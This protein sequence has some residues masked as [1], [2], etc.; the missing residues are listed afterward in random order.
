MSIC[1]KPDNKRKFK[2]AS[3]QLK[4]TVN[5]PAARDASCNAS[6]SSST[7]GSGG[8]PVTTTIYISGPQGIPGPTGPV[9]PQGP[10]PVFQIALDWK[11]TWVTGNTYH[12][13][14]VGLK[15]L[16]DIVK[17]EDVSYVCL[18]DHQSDATSTP[19][20]DEPKRTPLG[21]IY[22]T[23][24]TNYVTMSGTTPGAFDED[25]R[26]TL[27]K[28]AD[29]P[30]DFVNFVGK[31]AAAATIGDWLLAAALGA[32]I[33]YAGVKV[34]SGMSKTGTENST[35]ITY[36][37]SNGYSGSIAGGS[38]KSLLQNLCTFCGVTCDVTALT[39]H[40]VSMPI[41]NNPKVIDVIVELSNVY[42]FDRIESGGILK[43]IPRN[44]VPV[45]SLYL[46][47]IGYSN[48]TTVGSPIVY[49]RDQGINLPRQVSI[50]YISSAMDYG[51]FGQTSQLLSFDKGNDVTISTV[52]TLD[53]AFA[54]NL[55]DITLVNA[56]L[57]RS[58]VSFTTTL[59]QLE[60][61]V[62]DIV[63]L[64]TFGMVRILTIDENNDGLLDFVC[65]DAGSPT[66]IA[67]SEASVAISAPIASTN[68]T[69]DIGESDTFFLDLPP[70]SMNDTKSRLYACTHGYG[71]AGWPGAN[72]Y[73]SVDNGA[74]YSLCVTANEESTWGLVATAI[75]TV[76]HRIW[77]DTTVVTVVLKTGSLT[78]GTNTAVLN[79]ANRCM[80]GREMIAF[81]TATLTAPKTYQLTHLLRGRQGTDAFM[82]HEANELF[83][84][85]TDSLV[86]IETERTVP[87]M[88]K[89]VTIGSDISA[90][91]ETTAVSMG[92]NLTP[93]K[94]S[95]PIINKTSNDWNL[96]WQ[97]RLRYDNALKDSTDLT[98]DADFGGWAIAVLDGVSSVKRTAIVWTKSYTYT[99]AMQIIDF[100]SNQGSVNFSITALSTSGV[101]GYPYLINS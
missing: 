91:D 59:D 3:P 64:E 10:E 34:I 23:P 67:F 43:F 51:K 18:V 25:T 61:E 14:N 17:H 32:G 38:L 95:N 27:Q 66:N 28:I 52:I 80:V 8:T 96:T 75:S 13:G 41:S 20:V 29:G 47:D 98:H 82:V 63:D 101:T 72:I 4:K 65:C 45:K 1:P 70:L 93:W 6:A 50:T 86:L 31:W 40:S 78:S 58:T 26:S 89:T 81:G 49:K 87:V 68:I 33:I 53:D 83:V 92:T 5:K 42:Q 85:I 54:K 9:G 88:Y 60:L 30:S 79:G 71:L 100:G 84:L 48:S 37:G 24:L 62:G 15:Q 36:T 12:K 77:D 19:F 46:S 99:S 11:G 56:N 97:E 39:D 21:D 22:W 74:S 94:V 73:K 55:A 90:V 44:T 57:Q 76:N 35:N 2:K 69:V 16:Q 7:L